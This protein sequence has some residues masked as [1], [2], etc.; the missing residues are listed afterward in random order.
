M[1]I[2]FVLGRRDTSNTDLFHYMLL[3]GH[4]CARLVTKQHLWR[5]ATWDGARPSCRWRIACTLQHF[6]FFF[7]MLLV[8]LHS[9]LFST[10]VSV[11]C[12]PFF[13]FDGFYL[14]FPPPTPG[15]SNMPLLQLAG[16]GRRA[17]QVLPRLLLRVRQDA[18]RHAPEEV[19]QV[20]RRLRSKRLPPHLHRLKPLQ[21][22]RRRRRRPDEQRSQSPPRPCSSTCCVCVSRTTWASFNDA[23][24]IDSV[25]FF[26]LFFS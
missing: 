10:T 4:S 24:L 2:R 15:S 8:Q 13:V 17:D 20:Q 14:P 7:T 11:K 18:L 1:N 26:F 23:G 9:R 16:E 5:C 21:G 19:P 12:L 6:F 3:Q 25:N 22:R